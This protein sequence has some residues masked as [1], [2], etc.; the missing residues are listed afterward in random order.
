MRKLLQGYFDVR[1]STEVRDPRVIS[2]EG[3]AL[4]HVRSNTKR[5]MVSLFGNVNVTRLGYSQRHDASVFPLDQALNL[6]KG[7]YSSGLRK[8]LISEAIKGS[9]DESVQ[10][11][12][13]ST[14]GHVPKRQ[15]LMLVDEAS[16]DFCARLLQVK[17]HC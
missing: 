14:G 1:T 15:A 6:P 13:T 11:I 10:S 12:Q 7:Q 3:R 9:F 16:Q 8:R 2:P 4:N 5:N 17:F